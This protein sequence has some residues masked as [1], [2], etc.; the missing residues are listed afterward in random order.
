MPCASGGDAGR[1]TADTTPPPENSRLLAEN[2]R[3]FVDAAEAEAGE[4]SLVWIATALGREAIMSSRFGLG[5]V[6]PPE[7]FILRSAVRDLPDHWKAHGKGDM[8]VGCRLVIATREFY[9]L[10]ER[11]KDDDLELMAIGYWV[12]NARGGYFEGISTANAKKKTL[13]NLYK[14]F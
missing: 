10:L 1:V 2:T 6:D 7:N 14:R 11:D 5:F 12:P 3:V 9:C 8:P 13:S 4:F